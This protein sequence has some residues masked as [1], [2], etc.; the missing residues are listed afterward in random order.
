MVALT[1]VAGVGVAATGTF[2]LSRLLE[3]VTSSWTKSIICRVGFRFRILGIVTR[4]LG[5]QAFEGSLSVQ[6]NIPMVPRVVLR[7]KLT[8]PTELKI[9]ETPGL[10]TKL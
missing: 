7:R 9:I 1:F 4:G 10:W 5:F 3:H 6:F 2:A 8:T